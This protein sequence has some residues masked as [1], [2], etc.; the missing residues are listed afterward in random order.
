[1]IIHKLGTTKGDI[2]PWDVNV[3]MSTFT[4][5]MK[6]TLYKEITNLRYR[7][8]TLHIYTL[9]RFGQFPLITKSKY[10]KKYLKVIYNVDSSPCFVQ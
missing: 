2:P 1:M 9:K 10:L 5:I 3:I 8:A 4:V 6:S 7:N